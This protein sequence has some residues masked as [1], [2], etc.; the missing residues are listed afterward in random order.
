MKFGSKIHL[1]LIMLNDFVDSYDS[2][3]LHRTNKFIWW[4]LV[5]VKLSDD[6]EWSPPVMTLSD[7]IDLGMRMMTLNDV[8]L[9]D[10][11][12]WWNSFWFGNDQ[13]WIMSLSDKADIWMRMN[14]LEKCPWVTTLIDDFERRFKWGRWTTLSNNESL[15]NDVEG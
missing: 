5:K 4:P 13:S 7:Q 14:D 8:Q 10:D 3:E 2:S 12:A 9:S 11:L 6:F 15:H 1:S